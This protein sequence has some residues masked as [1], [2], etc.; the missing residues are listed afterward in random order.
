RKQIAGA[1]G[2]NFLTDVIKRHKFMALS[3]YADGIGWVWADTSKVGLERMVMMSDGLIEVMR[4]AQ[5]APRGISKIVVAALDSYRGKSRELDQIIAAKGKIMSAITA[6]SGDGL[7]KV[8]QVVD[9]KSLRV[10]VRATGKTLSEVVPA[11]LF[12]PAVTWG[13]FMDAANAPPPVLIVPS[14]QP[15]RVPPPPRRQ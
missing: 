3:L 11:A 15:T 10:T 8:S 6:Y 13:M 7:F 1:V 12:V 5:V 9:A 4:A 14:A 2:A